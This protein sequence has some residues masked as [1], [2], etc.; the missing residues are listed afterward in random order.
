[1][2]YGLV[3]YHTSLRILKS[4]NEYNQEEDSWRLPTKRR[5]AIT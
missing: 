5:L 3:T 2:S 4:E 1:M